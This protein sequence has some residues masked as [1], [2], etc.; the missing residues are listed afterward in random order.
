MPIS[1]EHLIKINIIF[2]V[3]ENIYNIFC[4]QGKDS[5]HENSTPSTQINYYSYIILVLTC[6]D[7]II[8]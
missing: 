4:Q 8:I 6:F 7:K 3:F 2:V 1:F 5:Y